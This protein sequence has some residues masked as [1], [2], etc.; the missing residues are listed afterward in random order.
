M[1]SQNEIRIDLNNSV[2]YNAMMHPFTRM[3]IKGALWYQ[4]IS[5][6]SNLKFKKKCAIVGEHNTGGHVRDKYNCAFAKLIESWRSIWHVRT[7]SSTD[8][9]FPFGFVQVS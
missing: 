6:S 5:L 2:L 3:V 7:N 9:T 8:P 1:D 4:G